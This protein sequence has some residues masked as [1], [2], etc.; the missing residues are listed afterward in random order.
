[1]FGS[2]WPVVNLVADYGR[3]VD[4]VDA[5]L[6]ALTRADQQKVWADNGERFYRL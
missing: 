2:D 6:G 4:T 3:W 5:L 1:M